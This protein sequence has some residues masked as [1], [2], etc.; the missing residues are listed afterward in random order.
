VIE[1]KESQSAAGSLM[2]EGHKLLPR[3]KRYHRGPYHVVK[4]IFD[5]VASAIALLLLFP[6][7]LIVSIFVAFSSGFPVLFKQQRVGYL[8]KPFYIYKFRTMVR[9][10]EDILKGRPDLMEEY[11]RNFKIEHDPRISK[12]GHFLRKYSLDE[13]PQLL[14]VIKGDMSLVGP[15]PI[16]VPELAKYGDSQDMYLAMHPGC[17]G[18][19]QCGGRSATSY[20]ERIALDREY[21]EKAG[22]RFDLY[23]IFRTVIAIVTARGAK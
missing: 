13:L 23:I 8:G 18:L 14:N 5:I 6:V 2:T 1:V 11:N 19:W 10:A 3:S 20:D 17:T 21:F 4:R 12:V 16:V 9:N 7:F 22:L 15:R